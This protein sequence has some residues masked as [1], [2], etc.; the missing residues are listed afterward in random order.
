MESLT[1]SGAITVTAKGDD[2]VALNHSTIIIEATLAAPK[3]DTLLVIA[4]TDSGTV[5]HTVTLTSGSFNTDGDTILTFNAQ[6]ELIVLY[7]V[8]DLQYIVLHNV[9]GVGTS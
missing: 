5:G 3:R 1:V 7:G 8:S 4:Q 2:Y 6:D 9:G